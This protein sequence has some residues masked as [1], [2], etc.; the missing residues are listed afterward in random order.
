MYQ[1]RKASYRLSKAIAMLIRGPACFDHEL[2][3]AKSADLAE[4]TDNKELWEHFVSDGQ[5]EGRVF[6]YPLR[7]HQQHCCAACQC[8][9]SRSSWL[10]EGTSRYCI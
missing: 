7:S 2:Y 10:L 5:F 6:R 3:R 1:D 8:L 9:L 4:L